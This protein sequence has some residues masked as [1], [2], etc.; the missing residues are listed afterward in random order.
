MGWDD[1]Y[2]RLLLGLQLRRV[3]ND[4]NP[5]PEPL[6]RILCLTLCN[7]S[8]CNDSE[9][10][11][12]CPTVAVLPSWPKIQEDFLSTLHLLLGLDERSE[13]KQ[14]DLLFIPVPCASKK[15]CT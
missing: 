9:R 10:G 1:P 12:I 3:G 7:D 5:E 13:R 2:F 14:Y 4:A 15:W 6:A 8:L 11:W